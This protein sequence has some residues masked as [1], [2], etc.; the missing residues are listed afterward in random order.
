MKLIFIISATTLGIVILTSFAKKQVKSQEELM[1]EYIEKN[2][3]IVREIEWN[4]CYEKV[5]NDAVAYV[6][7][8]IYQRVNFQISDTLKT[9]GRPIRPERPFDTLVLDTS[10]VRPMVKDTFIR[11]KNNI[12]NKDSITI[13]T[14]GIE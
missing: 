1:E 5:E 14:I 9:P 10:P 2:L 6:D 11:K 3:D 4:N 7:S 12:P 8:I 13:D